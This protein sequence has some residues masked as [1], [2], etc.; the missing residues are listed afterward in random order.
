MDFL[1]LR[2]KS[3]LYVSWS[4]SCHWTAVCIT[5]HK[6]TAVRKMMNPDGDLAAAVLKATGYQ[7]SQ[8]CLTPFDTRATQ[9]CVCVRPS[10]H[11]RTHAHN[12][13]T[14]TWWQGS[15][16]A[17]ALWASTQLQPIEGAHKKTPQHINKNS[18][19]TCDSLLSAPRE[20]RRHSLWDPVKET[21][22]RD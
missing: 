15:G 18:H 7:A 3:G 8:G 5:E 21:E 9:V 20:S 22:Q 1:A 17:P 13:E 19:T 11:T 16:R 14:D 10:V 12:E 4:F 2:S 6:W